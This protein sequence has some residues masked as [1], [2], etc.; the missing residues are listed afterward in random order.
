MR[1]LL[2]AKRQYTQH[3]LL[4]DRFGRL[5]ELPLALARRGHEVRGL[6][7]SY[8]P[9]PEGPVTD[10]SADRHAAVEWVSLNAGGLW[11]PGLWRYARRAARLASQFRPDIVWSTSDSLYG[12]LGRAI[13]RRANARH[14]FDLYDNFEYFA[15]TRIP[16]M[17]GAYRAAVRAADGVTCVSAPLASKVR[18]EYGRAGP[19]L[20]L[21]NGID[22]DR[23]ARR[24]ATHRHGRG[25]FGN[26][27]NPDAV[28]CRRTVDGRAR[29]GP[30]RAG[31]PARPRAPA[32]ERTARA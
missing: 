16:G 25:A 18:D 14:V 24:C 5:R 32:P 29:Q 9:R 21:P 19:T 8:A 7:L 22:R 31:R 30:F 26:T 10:R 27:R 1:L 4:D 3:D 28:S 17:R 2:L 20:V 23:P 13:A 11:L 12:V 6:C 15:T